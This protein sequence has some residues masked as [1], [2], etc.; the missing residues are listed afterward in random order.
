MRTVTED[1]VSADLLKRSWDLPPYKSPAFMELV[2]D[3]AAFR[4]LPAYKYAVEE[5]LIVNDQWA[6]E[7]SE[8]DEQEA[9][10]DELQAAA[11]AAAME[12]DKTEYNAKEDIEAEADGE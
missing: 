10:A 11:R 6:G 1:G 7:V 12:D 2:S 8:E 3:L 5:G 9:F 4:K